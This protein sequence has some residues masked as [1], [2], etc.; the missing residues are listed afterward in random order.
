VP[1]SSEHS[2]ADERFA[3]LPTRA[4][5]GGLTLTEAATRRARMKGLSKLAALPGDHALHIPR[6]RSV[7]TASMRF[8]LDLVWLDADGRV[9]R[10]DEGVGPRRLRTCLRARS[11]VEAAAGE[12]GRFAAALAQQGASR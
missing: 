3:G 8:A 11:V 4:L 7:Q 10:L 1:G 2:D 5:P 6:C 12:G 9:V